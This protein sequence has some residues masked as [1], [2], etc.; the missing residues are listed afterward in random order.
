MTES[1]QFAVGFTSSAL[2][3]INDFLII[4]AVLAVLMYA[5]S[6]AAMMGFIV[7]GVASSLIFRMSKNRS[8]IEQ[9]KGLS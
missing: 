5:Q 2:L 6:V 8:S 7:F 4:I 1:M 9:I 3:V